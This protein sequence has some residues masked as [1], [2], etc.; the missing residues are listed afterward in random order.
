MILKKIARVCNHPFT[1]QYLVFL[2]TLSSPIVYFR[3]WGLSN[4]KHNAGWVAVHVL[5]MCLNYHCTSYGLNNEQ[6]TGLGEGDI[7]ESV[8]FNGFGCLSP[9]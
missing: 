8:T 3:L 1:F 4:V 5:I 2:S 7:F 6:E 9:S